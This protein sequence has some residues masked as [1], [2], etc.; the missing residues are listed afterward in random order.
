M[1][2]RSQDRPTGDSG[3]TPPEAAPAGPDDVTRPGEDD[4]FAPDLALLA[5]APPRYGGP[6]LTLEPGDKIGEHYTVERQLGAGGM[7]VVH[8]AVDHRLG[9]K[10]AIKLQLG[11]RSAQDVHRLEREGRA[12]ASLSHPNVLG[13][14]AT[15]ERDEHLFIAMEFADGGTLQDWLDAGKRP[16]RDVVALFADLAAGLHAAHETGIVHRDFKPANVLVGED[17]RVRVVDFG[18]ARDVLVGGDVEETG[19]RD[20]TSSD[21]ITKTGAVVGTPAYMAPEQMRG[22]P[23]DGRTDQYSFCVTA[24]ELLYGRRPTSEEGPPEPAKDS[25]IP[26]GV[27]KALRKG[28]SRS[29]G[30]RFSELGELLGRLE[31]ERDALVGRRTRARW[32]WALLALVP[33]L[34]YGAVVLAGRIKKERE[35]EACALRADEISE[36][37]ND[38]A[39]TKL[40]QQISSS[41]HGTNVYVDAVTSRIDAFAEA[42]RGAVRQGCEIAVQ[43]GRWTRQQREAVD[44][45]LDERRSRF[46]ALIDALDGGGEAAARFAPTAAAG[47]ELSESCLEPDTLPDLP[48]PE[49]RGQERF[50]ELRADLFR[51][52]SLSE[53]GQTLDAERASRKA[54]S[55]AIRLG[56]DPLIAEA[57]LVLHD[58]TMMTEE[59]RPLKENVEQAYVAAVRSGSWLVAADVATRIASELSETSLS[60]DAL[61][62]LQ[63]GDA[64]LDLSGGG[65]EIRRAE[66]S[67]GRCDV[68]SKLEQFE[69][70]FAEGHRSVE[71]LTRVLGAEH[72]RTTAAMEI[73]ALLYQRRSEYDEAERLFLETLESR[74]NTLGER[75]LS[76][77]DSHRRLGD[78]YFAQTYFDKATVH[79]E[80]AYEIAMAAEGEGSFATA[81]PAKA[82]ARIRAVRGNAKASGELSQYAVEIE[83]RVLKGSRRTGLLYGLRLVANAHEQTGDIEAA[84]AAWADSL[85]IA[86]AEKMDTLTRTELLVQVAQFWTRQEREE[87]T[88]DA[89]GQALDIA[90]SELGPEHHQVAYILHSRGFGLHLFGHSEEGLRQCSEGLAIW[91]RAVSDNDM[92]CSWMHENLA[93]IHMDT[94]DYSKALVEFRRAQQIRL[95]FVDPGDFL[96][97][98]VPN[99]VDKLCT[100]HNYQPACD[101]PLR[102]KPE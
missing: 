58:A 91:E 16:W 73:L 93:H 9:R 43:Q 94:G 67:K 71:T 26:P 39:R 44:W 13:V 42:W 23:L 18:L 68:L 56:W 87:E 10:V 62:W 64:A 92:E 17:E 30:R 82:L 80:R 40:A 69:E 95:P 24:W 78:L 96:G 2:T 3:R 90:R 1:T 59:K 84:A 50:A 15:G 21:Q 12:M 55:N 86:N 22:D 32:R 5:A 74:K 4:D 83:K 35:L 37:W 25:P 101:D 70:G 38:A 27:E 72:P 41:R 97:I 75:S 14:Y 66:I 54:L 85:R 33:L 36:T 102:A 100:E 51:A 46:A 31:L 45:C 65:H 60:A 89:Y 48:S 34:A 11:H 99:Y 79:L 76:A 8:L 7:G 19:E 47:L 77:A 29:P 53:T 20:R 28:L 88:L 98:R 63:L 81:A 52:R 6:P 49:L 61:L 57:R